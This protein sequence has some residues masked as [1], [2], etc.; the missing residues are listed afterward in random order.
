SPT[1]HVESAP[2]WRTRY[3]VVWR[4]RLASEFPPA[5]IIPMPAWQPRLL[6]HDDRPSV[7]AIERALDW[8][9]AVAECPATGATRWKNPSA[10]S[11]LAVPRIRLDLC[12]LVTVRFAAHD[13]DN[14]PALTK[15][16]G[17]KL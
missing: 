14:R 6:L 15:V 2:V 7:D 3:L 8:Q 17:V 11:G 13:P 16:H 9:G 4:G 10:A 5:R 12:Y 1:Q